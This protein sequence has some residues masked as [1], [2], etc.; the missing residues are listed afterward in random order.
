MIA[1]L[2]VRRPGP[3]SRAGPLLRWMPW[4]LLLLG[5][6]AWWF[7]QQGEM[8][9]HSTSV[10]EKASATPLAAT[11]N[12]GP[13]ATQILGAL[14]FVAAI[15][16]MLPAILRRFASPHRAAAPDRQIQV[17]ET[18]RLDKHTT[19]WLLAVQGQEVLVGGSEQGLT[20]LGVIEPVDVNRVEPRIF[21][22]REE[23]L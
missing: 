5:A 1:A 16:Y 2:R 23:C 3:S 21:E 18:V 13:P 4:V 6:T 9:G 20:H 11:G 15:L 17:R 10:G 14:L 22:P 12:E 7:T 19:L 8:L